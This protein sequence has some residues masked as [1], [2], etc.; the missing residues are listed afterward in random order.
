MS[1]TIYGVQPIR[2]AI[3]AQKRIAVLYL[4]RAAG[5]ATRQLLADARSAGIRVIESSREDLDGR[6]PE[7]RHQ[8]AVAVLEGDEVEYADV[9]AI[10]ARAE[11][12]GEPPLV[13]ILDGIQ[14]PRNLG[15]LV[16]S[17][18]A[19]GAHGVVIPKQRAA[20]IT[21][22]A[23][24]TSAGA[25]AHLPIAQV[26]NV[27]HAL[28]ELREAGV[29]SAATV[30][31]GDPLDK[32]RL[33]GPLALV[34]GSEDKGVRPSVAEACDMRVRIPLAHDFDSLNASVAGGIFLYEVARQRRTRGS[35]GKSA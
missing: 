27:K 8:G 15:A 32:V 29:W 23:V 33:D 17:A 30:L 10:L 35:G 7:G 5:G 13:L 24:K 2:E 20:P 34:I 18:H 1:A 25:T 6:A 9:A 12:A 16:R 26:V 4:S 31:D 28:D 19:L 3:R 14:D 21:P 11:E 22:A